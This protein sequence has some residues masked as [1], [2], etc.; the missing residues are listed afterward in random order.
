MTDSPMAISSYLCRVV[1]ESPARVAKLHATTIKRSRAF[2]IALHIPV[3]LWWITGFMVA[4][5]IFQL[6]VA[7]SAGVAVVCASLIYA[8]ERLVILAPKRRAI[9]IVRGMI[10]LLIATLGALTFDLVIFDREVTAQLRDNAQVTIEKNYQEKIAKQEKLVKDRRQAWQAA[11]DKANC[12]ANGTCGSGIRSTGPIYK[13]LKEIANFEKTQYLAADAELSR[14]T[15]EHSTAVLQLRQGRM[16]TEQAGLLDR[17]AAFHQRVM[18]DWTM[19]SVAGLFFFFIF[20]LELMVLFVK[21][22]F[23]ETIDDKIEA[24]HASIQ[25]RKAIDYQQTLLSPMANPRALAESTW[26]R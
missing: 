25:E 4:W 19:L 5:K 24:I 14:L 17:I 10:G 3:L 8:I 1:G 16:V 11:E 22:A 20:M 26:M 12:E 23:G 21:Q 18:N 15:Q 9:A 6:E 13:N 7:W 2:A